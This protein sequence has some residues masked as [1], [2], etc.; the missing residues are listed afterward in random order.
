[1]EIWSEHYDRII[2][3]WMNVQKEIADLVVNSLQ[4]EVDLAEQRRSLKIP[5][6][7]LDAWSAYHRGRSFMFRFTPEDCSRAEH[8]FRR[9]IELDPNAPRGYAGLS[10][11]HYQR[12]LLNMSRDLA[13]E[14]QRAHDLAL[15]SLA[16]DG[17]DPMGHWAL[18]RAIQ[19][20]GELQAAKL[21]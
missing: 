16:A 7:N 4:S 19:L 18:G 13:G 10:F 5:S 8:F 15:R 17:S 9:S 20:R 2:D 12:V 14:T 11:V 21:E 6:A 1:Q 3:D